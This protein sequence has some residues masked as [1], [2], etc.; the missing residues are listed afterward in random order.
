MGDLVW[1]LGELLIEKAL[2]KVVVVLV[3]AGTVT[4]SVSVA[5]VVTAAVLGVSWLFFSR[6]IQGGSTRSSTPTSGNCETTRDFD[7]W[8][9]NDE[10]VGKVLEVSVVNGTVGAEDVVIV[11]GTIS[12]KMVPLASLLGEKEVGVLHWRKVLDG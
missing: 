3:E 12:F 6:R 4:V 8:E 10:K 5:A 9:L 1:S 2:G 7:I 11:F